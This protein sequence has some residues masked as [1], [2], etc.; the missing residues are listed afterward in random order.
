MSDK[1]K[2]YIKLEPEH[3]DS[4]FFA[5]AMPVIAVLCLI[6]AFSVIEL[7]VPALILLVAAIVFAWIG[8]FKCSKIR[9]CGGTMPYAKTLATMG[10]IVCL[11]IIIAAISAAACIATAG[12]CVCKLLGEI[13]AA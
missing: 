12:S 3:R 13:S 1:D 6:G 11:L 10:Y 2:I 8:L 5:V 4:G 9:K 7:I